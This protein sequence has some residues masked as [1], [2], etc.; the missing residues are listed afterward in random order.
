MPL[1][2]KTVGIDQKM[3]D[4]RLLFE[5]VGFFGR[6][7]ASHNSKHALLLQCADVGCFRAGAPPPQQKDRNQLSIKAEKMYQAEVILA[8][9]ATS[10]AA[11][12]TTLAS[13]LDCEK[14]ETFDS[15]KVSGT[16]SV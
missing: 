9:R 3:P 6:R 14:L 13:D 7:R 10:L 16:S 2:S 1:L 12:P 8:P 4:V 15:H 11:P 5:W